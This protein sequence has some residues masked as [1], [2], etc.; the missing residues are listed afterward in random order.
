MRFN[1]SQYSGCFIPTTT[2]LWYDLPHMI[3]ETAK[4]QKFK[5]GATAFNT[6]SLNILVSCLLFVLAL[7][8][9]LLFVFI[10]IFIFFI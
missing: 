10:A 6:Q 1:T 7:P 4:L 8:H 9:I 5:L 2:K 3:K